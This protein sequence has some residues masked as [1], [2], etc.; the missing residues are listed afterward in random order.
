MDS[1][2]EFALKIQ[3]VLPAFSMHLQREFEKY[4]NVGGRV[5]AEENNEIQPHSA[6]NGA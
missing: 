3:C 4:K 2:L 5:P 1:Y 6:K